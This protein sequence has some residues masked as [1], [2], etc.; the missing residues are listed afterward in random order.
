MNVRGVATREKIRGVKSVCRERLLAQLG[1]AEHGRGGQGQLS[2]FSCFSKGKGWRLFYIDGFRF[3][4]SF[5]VFPP[6]S[7]NSPLW[8]VLV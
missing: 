4:F 1:G 6:V 8:Y 5:L 2:W 7:Q 3:R